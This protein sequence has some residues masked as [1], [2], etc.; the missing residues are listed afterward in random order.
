MKKII[1]SI[2]FNNF[3][4]KF[5]LKMKLTTFFVVVSLFQ[6]KANDSYSQTTKLSLDMN[7]VMVN[8]VIRK[9]ES[10]SEFKFLY[11]RKDVDLNRF[12]SVRVKKKRIT[13]ILSSIFLDSDTKFEVFNKQIV[14]KRLKEQLKTELLEDQE[15]EREIKGIVK[16]DK[17]NPLAGANVL[18]KG[19]TI[20][21]QTGFDG[22]FTLQIP[23]DSNV[24]VVSYIGFS[25]NEISINGRTTIDIT[26]QEDAAGLDE[27][28]IVGYGTQ[29]KRNVAGSISS[30]DG[31]AV[32]S[33]VTG[34]LTQTLV[35]RATG[36]RVETSG[37]A[38][39]AT[40]NVIIR[41]TGS[42]SNQ[43]PLYVVDGVFSDDISFLNPSD[44]ESIQVLKDA[45]TA[46]IYGARSG[47]GVIIVSTKK[48]VKG[49]AMKVDFDNS[50]G[51]ASVIRQI[52]YLNAADY[53]ANRT[54][55]YANDGNPL[56]E[57]F[58]NF[59]SSVDSDIQDASLRSAIV[60]NYGL[61]IY[62]GGEESTYSISGNRLI[63]EGV[64]QE[65]DYERTTFRLNTST[66]KGRFSF[67]QAL[68]LARSINQP[69][70]VFG[71]EYGHLPII[72]ILDN[73]LDGGFAAANTGIAGI[74]RSAN[75]LGIATLTERRN[76]NDNVLA[77]ISGGFKIIDGLKYILNLSINY[78]N[79]KRFVF[80]P[81]YFTSNSDVGSNPIA[82]LTE[83]KSTF[84]STIV[85]NLFTYKKNL[86]N[87]NLDLLAGYS[88]QKDKT[89]TLGVSVKNF[90]SNDTRTI[91]AGSDIVSRE[92]VVLPRIIQSVFG[93]LNYDYTG[94]YLFSVS[95]RRDGS[96]NF[97][98][99]NRYGVFPSIG[100]GWNISEESFFKVD[101]I[102]NLK[103]RGSWGK[104][105]SD[106]LI[107]FQYVTALNIT[108]Q[109]TLGT[110]QDRLNGVSKIQFSNPDLK[111]EE[112]TTTDIGIEASLFN[113]KI[114]L[115][116]DYF[117]KKSEDI[118][119]NLPINPSSGS[120]VSIPFNVATVEN[121]GFEFLLA[122]KK[123]KGD[124]QY[125]ITGGL[126]ALDNKV[127]DLGE[128]V[129]PITGG[130]FTNETFAATRTE[131]T[132]PVSYFYGYKTNGVY[133]NQAEI[134]ADNLSG[135]TAV[136]GDLRFVDVE[137]NGI[138]DANDQ[139]FLGSPIPD[140]E[141]SLNFTGKYKDLDFGLFFQGVQ[142]NEIWNG[143]IYEGIFAINGPK[144]GLAKDAWT[145]SNPS[146]TIPRASIGDSGLNKRSSDFYIED[147]SYFSLKN[148]TLG[149]S[150][151]SS[152]IEKIHLY[153]L[154]AYVNVENT[155]IID[156][157]SGYYPE[158]GRNI[159]RANS[160]F[161]R[162]VD[163][164]AYPTART[165]TLGVQLSF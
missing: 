114:D 137:P 50:L 89:E 118:L 63:Q 18:V 158:I 60:Q 87:H 138:L 79:R 125:T 131:T 130:M 7:H 9:I 144:L 30:I 55:A 58:N 8:D 32:S 106:N 35:G 88:E 69:N 135:R 20:G 164:G 92:G 94:R 96:S 11:N 156:N 46:S 17:G 53:I 145:P 61:R 128:G 66:K 77:N 36:V 80:V 39:G 99:D 71:R 15:Q 83:T 142:G 95:I 43:N 160:L 14:L 104:L 120:N 86:G 3:L 139:T 93:R 155:F 119:A 140:I 133:Q 29:K 24:L 113:G 12:V 25:T 82:N 149:Y 19:T 13:A 134:D 70:L 81:T 48:G 157:Y 72:P 108:S 85:E 31:D 78:N 150:L 143:R 22:E 23:E 90:I 2:V 1:N 132:F 105:G 75:Y 136:P 73:T 159:R 64:V 28:I 44:I 163:E 146:N 91:D 5:D 151:P 76:T 165:I 74:S 52:D 40:A 152:V 102:D 110:G 47:Q 141:Y 162:G 127:L 42:L 84:L 115:I 107:P 41:G 62:G 34:N 56:P 45:S 27:V 26:M 121:K 33:S 161:D 124:F 10:L 148:I 57:N 100:L 123:N 116:I 21:T 38:P 65:S 4:W 129:S 101:A 154:R 147:G 112:T 68:F 37:G 103:L 97:G 117:Q 111:W 6:L 98:N 59:D 51:F 54:Q 16:D 109:Y 67:S 122:Y 153:K 49:Q 126:T